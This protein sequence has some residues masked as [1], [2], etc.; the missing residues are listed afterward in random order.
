MKNLNK[1]ILDLPQAQKEFEQIFNI[2]V[3]ALW[4]GLNG[5]V[6]LE[7]GNLHTEIR[8]NPDGS[9]KPHE[10]GDWTFTF[11][12]AWKLLRDNEILLDTATTENVENEPIVNEL[13]GKTIIAIEFH[14]DQRLATVIFDKGLTVTIEKGEFGILSLVYNHHRHLLY[15]DNKAY[16]MVYENR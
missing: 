7:I 8:K 9:P 5:T 14:T 11:S 2:P 13:L 10:T 4:C 15:S 16:Y 1:T 6:G 12:G 3:A